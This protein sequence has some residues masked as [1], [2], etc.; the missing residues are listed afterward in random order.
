VRLEIDGSP[1]SFERDG[2][3]GVR[4]QLRSSAPLRLERI[5]LGS[6]RLIRDYHHARKLE[7][8]ER[9]LAEHERRFG[10][11]PPALQQ[12]LGALGARLEGDGGEGDCQCADDREGECAHLLLRSQ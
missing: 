5:L 11:L 3:R 4:F 12:K 10:E 2:L 7:F 1:Q 8:R 6:I 9:V